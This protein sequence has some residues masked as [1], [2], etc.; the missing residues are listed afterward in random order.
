MAVTAR[1]LITRAYY[2]S[3]VVA[4]ELQTVSG[5]QISDGLYLLN[6]LLD[7]KSSDLHLIPYFTPST[8]TTVIGQSEYFV[9]NLVFVDSMTFNIGEVRYAM[10][11]MDRKGFFATPR[12]DGIQSLPF[13]YRCER[14]L[15]GMNIFFY[16]VPAGNYVIKIWGKFGFT[17]VTLDTDLSLIYDRFYIEYLRYALAQYICQ[18][19]GA[20]FP[21][22]ATAKY[23]E[24]VKKLM[25]QSPADLTIQKRSY[26]TR[27]PALD[28]QLVNIP[29]WVPF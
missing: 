28:W 29:G 20:T 11:E 3:Q 10:I 27:S 26:F 16:F 13:S 14:T 12:V 7:V 2:L 8:F 9:E 18:D 6:A 15:D 5:S 4:R 21:Q 24:I 23:D 25:M 1:E 17:E 22:E 19:W